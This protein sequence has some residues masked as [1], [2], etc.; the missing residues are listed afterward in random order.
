M[1][2]ILSILYFVVSYL[3]PA[4]IFGSFAQY[5]IELILA[6]LLLLVSMP[7][8]AGS[9]VFKT[10][11]ALALAGLAVA[12]F[13][14][15]LFGVHWAG[16]AVQSFMA[17]LP[18]IYAYFMVCLHFNSKARL[19][20]LILVLLFVCL[21]DLVH[22]T[23][24]LRQISTEGAPS[25][26]EEDRD[27]SRSLWDLNH[28]YV[29]PMRSDT[30]EW[31]YRIRGLGFINDPNDFGQLLVTSMPLLIF[32]WDSEKRI[33]N[34]VLVLLPVCLL[35]VAVFLTHS[36]GA[37]LALVAVVLV[38]SRRRIGTVPAGI[39]A[40]LLLIAAMALQFT[41]GRAISADTGADRTALWGGGLEV[42]KSYPLFGVGLGQLPDYL[43]Q[44]A[45][46]SI[47][48]CA[49]ELGLVGLYFWSLFI[50]SSV[51][52]AMVIASPEQISE[53]RLPTTGESPPL[54]PIWKGEHL[55]RIDVN[56]MGLS[57]LLSLTGFLVSAWFLSRAFVMTFF[58]LGGIVQVVYEEAHREGMH[59]SKIPLPRLL[60]YTLVLS[61]SLLIA[62]YFLVRILNRMH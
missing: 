39:L 22:A 44:T 21:F 1:G 56:R 35:L 50:L 43:G 52:N 18:S 23:I 31:F 62:V 11:Q 7:K 20:A 58:L 2:F 14:S 32:F 13:C 38:A 17:F 4:T 10:A 60:V 24:E 15:V 3:T 51:R 41:G 59:D 40:G 45:H 36:R 37:L 54:F 55:S 26:V 29:L 34:L 47:M 25:M 48:V 6:I 8:L 5:R 28:P 61:G 46:N 12:V 57:L 33:R 16:G 53:V 27:S 49:A 42:L 30:G 9:Y 19:K